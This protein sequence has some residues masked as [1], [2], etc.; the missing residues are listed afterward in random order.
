[1]ADICAWVSTNVSCQLNES[2][3]HSPFDLIMQNPICKVMQLLRTDWVLWIH[4]DHYPKVIVTFF[5]FFTPTIAQSSPD[6]PFLGSPADALGTSST[7]CHWRKTLPMVAHM[8]VQSQAVLCVFTHCR[9][10]PPL[11]MDLLESSRSQW[12]QCGSV[13]SEKGESAA[14]LLLGTALVWDWAQVGI[15]GV[16]SDNI[17]FLPSCRESIKVKKNK[18]CATTLIVS[19]SS[20]VCARHLARS[21]Y[22]W[23][24]S[25]NSRKRDSVSILSTFSIVGD[26]NPVTE[27][28]YSL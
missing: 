23:E 8:R 14:L 5:F 9:S 20:V 18:S 13:Y 17:K 1:M 21:S 16:V 12:L 11:S 4:A 27:I 24:N 22:I 7:L 15:W 25:L 28:F 10:V 2:S 19:R 3:T 26:L 6:T